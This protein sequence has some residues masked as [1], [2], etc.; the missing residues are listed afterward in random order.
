MKSKMNNICRFLVLV[1]LDIVFLRNINSIQFLVLASNQ[2]ET[3]TISTTQW[4]KLS[5][6]LDSLYDYLAKQ[7]EG[8]EEE[9]EDT[10]KI[11]KN[12]QGNNSDSSSSSSSSCPEMKPETFCAAYWDPYY[13]PYMAENG[14]EIICRYGNDCEASSSG[15]NITTSSLTSDCYPKCPKVDDYSI[16]EDENDAEIDPT[17]GTTQQYTCLDDCYYVGKCEVEQVGLDYIVDC[18]K[19]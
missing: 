6:F 13:C 16:C 12:A 11:S 4:K 2:T 17:T 9:E 10:E 5:A 7:Q 19:T 8:E 3:T 14:T 1:L 18:V 15:F